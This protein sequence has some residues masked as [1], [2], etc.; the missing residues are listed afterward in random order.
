[1]E[2][3]WRVTVNRA[4]RE[5]RWV[6]RDSERRKSGPRISSWAPAGGLLCKR[7]EGTGGGKAPCTPHGLDGRTEFM[8]V[9]R[10]RSDG[11]NGERDRAHADRGAG[12][13]YGRLLLSITF[14]WLGQ[15]WRDAPLEIGDNLRRRMSI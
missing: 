1:M 9:M 13:G 15:A 10:G 8:V 11:G 3:V 14:P 7:I 5:M 4:V 2:C 6:G 12:W